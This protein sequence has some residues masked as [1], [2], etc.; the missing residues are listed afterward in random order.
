MNNNTKPGSQLLVLLAVTLVCFIAATLLIVALSAI[1]ID[2]ASGWPLYVSQTLSQMIMFLLPVYIVVRLYHSDNPRLYMRADFG[3]RAWMLSLVGMAAM[4][5]MAPVNDWLTTWNDSWTFGRFDAPLRDMQ[6]QTEAVT[7]QLLGG[8]DAGSLLLNL[9]VVALVP[10][11]C[12]EVF[13]RAGMQNLLQRWFTG[14]SVDGR[15]AGS[16]AAIV[17]TAAVFSLAHGELYS[18]MPR[19]VMGILLG[20]LYVYGGSIVVN[21]AAHFINNAVVVLIYWLVARGVLD[22]DPSAPMNIPWLLTTCCTVASLALCW[23][24]FSKDVKKMKISS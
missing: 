13:F 8:S 10:A 3:R 17:V 1:G 20:A 16:V 9:L 12:E 24:F 4:L 6:Q 2:A 18:F 22:I 11:V 15:K 5:L 7:A 14:G 23:A 21:V 19:F